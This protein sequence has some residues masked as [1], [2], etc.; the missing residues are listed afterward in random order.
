MMEQDMTEIDKT[1]DAVHSI[2]PDLSRVCSLQVVDV[3]NRSETDIPYLGGEFASSFVVIA[4]APLVISFNEMFE[5]GWESNAGVSNGYC[6]Y[7]GETW[8]GIS[9]EGELWVIERVCRG[10]PAAV[11]ALGSGL[12]ATR[13]PMAAAQLAELNNPEPPRYSSLR[14]GSYW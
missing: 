1:C 9:L 4:P 12:V 13:N 5:R 3:I 6:R 7:I 2:G 11:L 8:L 14:W 10:R